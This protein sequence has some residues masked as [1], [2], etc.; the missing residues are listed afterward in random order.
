M[1]ARRDRV[2]EAIEKA[3][4]A[5]VNIST[6]KVVNRQLLLGFEVFGPPRVAHSLGTGGIFTPDGYA[7]TNAHVVNQASRISVKLADGT[8]Y[9]AELVDVDVRNDLAVIKIAADRPLPALA[10][11]RSGDL[12]VGEKVIAVGNPFGLENSVTTGIVSATRRDVTDGD[13]VVFADVVQTDAPINPGNSGGPLLNVFGE[14]VGIN[15]AIRGDAEGIGFAIPVDRVKQSLASILDYRRLRRMQLGLDLNSEAV[16][17]GPIDRLIVAGVVKDG[18]ADKSGVR[19]GDVVVSV[20]GRPVSNLT[21]FMAAVLSTEG[22]TIAMNLDRGG[23][24]V[25]ALVRADRIPMPD[26]GEL[27]SSMLG[28]SVQQMD[29]SL[30]GH[31]GINIDHGILVAG[32]SEGSAA[33]KVGIKRGDLILQVNDVAVRT[34]DEL[35]LV[36]ESLQNARSLYLD[37]TR[38][39]GYT[40]LRTT[41]AVPI[42]KP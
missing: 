14:V 4:P 27:A 32:V 21:C 17:D 28:L 41:V 25:A 33:A 26:A 5:V 30:A 20:A 9:P 37:V 18:P 36:L 3:A 23:K 22:D 1:A 16:G 38:V 11:G 19:N 7:F 31:V 29:S 12:M 34:M 35:A 40:V 2:V 6:D 15:S 39:R 10:L 13:R 8:E 24:A 42:Q